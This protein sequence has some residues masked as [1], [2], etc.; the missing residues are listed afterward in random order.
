MLM[1]PEKQALEYCLLGEAADVAALLLT[2]EEELGD[3]RLS[4]LQDHLPSGP[5]TALR[6]FCSLTTL[7]RSR[8]FGT[9]CTAHSQL[10]H[11]HHELLNIPLLVGPG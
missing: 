1:G 11:F 4:E 7:Y 5:C 2:Q 10:Q 8:A 9:A 6:G 3:P